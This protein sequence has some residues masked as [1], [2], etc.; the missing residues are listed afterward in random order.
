MSGV[1]DEPKFVDSAT[2]FVD[3]TTIA[4]GVCLLHVFNAGLSS[5]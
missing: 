5:K 2:I 1:P 4:D 3:S